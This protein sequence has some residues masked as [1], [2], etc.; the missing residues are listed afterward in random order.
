MDGTDIEADV[1]VRSKIRRNG[2]KEDDRQQVENPFKTTLPIKL[3]NSCF[4]FIVPL[5]AVERLSRI[6]Y[7]TIG[8]LC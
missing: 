8:L 5:R 4:H 3:W 6:E 2:R 7:L 1:A